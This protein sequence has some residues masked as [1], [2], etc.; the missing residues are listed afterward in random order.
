[1]PIPSYALSC[2]D[3]AMVTLIIE[4]ILF[5][6]SIREDGEFQVWDVTTAKLLASIPLGVKV[7]VRV[8]QQ[9]ISLYFTGASVCNANQIILR[10]ASLRMHLIIVTF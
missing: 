3:V 7:C 4:T 5:A 2:D 9:H 8:R 6:Q 1:M 10:P